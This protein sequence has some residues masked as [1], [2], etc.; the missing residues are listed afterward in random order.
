MGRKNVAIVLFEDIEVLDFTGPFEVFTLTDELH[1]HALFDV[2]TVAEINQPIR[3]KNGLSINPDFCFGDCPT[4]HILIVPGGRGTRSLI[5]NDRILA[6]ILQASKKAELVLSVCTGSLVL[7]RTGM[8]DGLEATTH[9]NAL[10]E[11]AALA[12]QIKVRGDKR[13]IDT[14]KIVTSGGI[15]TG[16][17]MSLYIVEKL[18]G[19]EYAAETATYMAYK[20]NL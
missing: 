20:R 4:P 19:E 15:S 12:P 3:A 13:F 2:Y 14:G 8:L 18:L 16:I 7:A 5:K 6:W 9:K 1:D 10:G 11:L 17:D